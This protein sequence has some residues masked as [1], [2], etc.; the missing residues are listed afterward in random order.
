M[1]NIELIRMIQILTFTSI[2]VVLA[3][4]PPASM[5]IAED[6][7]RTCELAMDELLYILVNNMDIQL[8][9]NQ[10]SKNNLQISAENPSVVFSYSMTVRLMAAC[11]A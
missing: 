1:N 10:L 9:G 11:M 2:L 5:A 8:F 3:M 4:T 7:N 6:N